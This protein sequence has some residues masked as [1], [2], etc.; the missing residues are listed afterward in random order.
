[1]TCSYPKTGGIVAGLM[2][3][4]TG[5]SS[6][7]I[8]ELSAQKESVEANQFLR[9]QAMRKRLDADPYINQVVRGCV[10]V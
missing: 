7:K 2:L 5:T 3:E 8:K 1:M 9:D 4:V 10:L 6:E